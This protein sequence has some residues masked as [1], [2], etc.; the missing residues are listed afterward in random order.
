MISNPSTNSRARKWPVNFLHSDHLKIFP[1]YFGFPL[2]PAHDHLLGQYK[3]YMN[4]PMKNSKKELGA[5]V[6]PSRNHARQS[7]RANHLLFFS[8]PA[9]SAPGKIMEQRKAHFLATI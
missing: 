5:R 9:D 1:L 3:K 6:F 7:E 2:P 4:R 8:K